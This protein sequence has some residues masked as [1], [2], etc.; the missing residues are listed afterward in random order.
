MILFQDEAASDI[1]SEISMIKNY[2]QGY[3]PALST[4]G[5]EAGGLCNSGF[6]GPVSKA[7]LPANQGN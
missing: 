3:T 1:H 2:A 6:A 7:I 4:W 5:V